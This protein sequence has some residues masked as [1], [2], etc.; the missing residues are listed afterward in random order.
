MGVAGFGVG[1]YLADEV[2]RA[3]YLEGVP[4]FFLLYYQ[5]SANHL[6]GGRDVEQKGFSLDRR[7]QDQGLRQ[8][9]LNHVKCLLG[10]GCPF[11]AIGLLQKSIKG[12]T[13]F[14]EA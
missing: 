14:V 6:R 2:H 12:E 10:L 5:G 11:E 3:L 8:N 9:L 7:N 13:S 4:L 1:Q